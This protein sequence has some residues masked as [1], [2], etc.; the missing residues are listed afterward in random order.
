[1]WDDNAHKLEH[2]TEHVVSHGP[3]VCTGQ[4]CTIHNMT[5]HHMRSFTQHW[6]DDRGI[7]ERICPHGVGHPDPDEYAV[8]IGKDSGV[9][10]CCGTQCC[11][12]KKK[13]DD[14]H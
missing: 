1:M 10:G 2:S 12:V 3:N 5:N 7:M 4:A 13:G 14:A 11:R 6:R 9:H 8:R